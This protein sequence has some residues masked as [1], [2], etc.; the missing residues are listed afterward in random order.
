MDKASPKNRGHFVHFFLKIR[1][2]LS[3]PKG[4]LCHRDASSWGRFVQG[5]D[6]PDD[7]SSRGTLCY[8]NLGDGLL[9]GQ[10]MRGRFVRVP[11]F[12]PPL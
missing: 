3:V 2:G 11:D 4:T 10:I 1:D 7:I 5:M 6:C 8:Q 9:R 12:Q